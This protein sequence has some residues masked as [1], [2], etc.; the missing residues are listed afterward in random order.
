M[1]ER[2]AGRKFRVKQPH[3]PDPGDVLSLKKGERLHC[4]R[5]LTEWE[6]WLWCTS[7]S[8]ASAW[9]PEAYVEVE[10]GACVMLRDYVSRE[11]ALE[12]GRKVLGLFTE[13]GWAWVRT[14]EG[15]EGWVPLDCLEC[16]EE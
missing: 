3:A 15:E 4:K 9:V 8:G 5:R 2:N 11:L 14:V 1:S 7:E 16:L 10:G 12:V 13:S 6:G